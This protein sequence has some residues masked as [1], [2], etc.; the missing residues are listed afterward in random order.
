MET[1]E[2]VPKEMYD[3]FSARKEMQRTRAD[4]R[5]ASARQ[6]TQLECSAAQVIQ[7]FAL[8]HANYTQAVDLLKERFGQSHI[9]IHAYI[10]ALLN[11]PAP[12]NTLHSMRNYI[13]KLEAHI[14][15]LKSLGQFQNTYG[16][17]LVPVIIEKLPAKICKSLARENDSDKRFLETS[18]RALYRE[19]NIMEAG[20]TTDDLTCYRTTASFFTGTRQKTGIGSHVTWNSARKT[21]DDQEQCIFCN[22]CH[23][24]KNCAN[25]TDVRARK[26]IIRNKHLCFNCWNIHHQVINC[27]SNYRCFKCRR[28]HHTSICDSSPDSNLNIGASESTRSSTE[29]QPT[30]QAQ[31]A[32]LQSSAA[33]E[34]F[35]DYDT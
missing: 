26:D 7:G 3:S 18:R 21:F 14:R 9:I 17:L 20:Q 11:L 28:K 29:Y 13:D 30:N 34:A 5:N 27:P 10:Q 23:N 1:D 16:T 24:T 25:V 19:L 6:E 12:N 35:I 32:I 22:E 2:D 15:G 33:H 31:I 4:P 8:T